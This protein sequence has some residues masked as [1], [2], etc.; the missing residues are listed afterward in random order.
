MNEIESDARRSYAPHVA[1][2]AVQVFFGSATVLGKFALL[3]F[4][5]DALVGFRVGGAALAFYLLQR[6]RGSLALDSG[7]DYWRFALFAFFG[8]ALN[9][10]LFFKGL[11][12][13][14]A[15]NTALIA[16]TIPIFTILIGVL[17]GSDSLSWRKFAGITLAAAG[18][19]YLINPA[20][21]SFG[22][23]TTRGDILIVLNS[24]CYAAYVATSKKLI[25]Q[26]GALKSIAWLFLFA[27][28]VNVPMGLFALRGVDLG[29]VSFNSWLFVAGLVVF[30]TIMAYFWNAWALA[31][32]EPSIV[33]VYI[34]LQPLIGFLAAI[35]FLGE[36]F[37]V[38]LL[39]SA[40]LVFAGVFLVTKKLNSKAARREAEKIGN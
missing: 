2:F 11:S 31:R 14:T 23:E 1:L 12:L 22:S 18:V 30:P 17:L 34:Y 37:S 8:V 32:V 3:A 24:L 38:R 19:V 21:A 15:V 9:Q 28:L 13:T 26:Y 4:P 40:I 16:V 39:I 36:H 6:W 27:S 35:L 25:R 29:A 10:L 7:R 20:G 5:P 33:A